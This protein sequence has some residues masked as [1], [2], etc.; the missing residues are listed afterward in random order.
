MFPGAPDSQGPPR[1]GVCGGLIYATDCGQ[2]KI[3][4]DSEN[5]R[6]PEFHLF[7]SYYILR[8]PHQV[9]LVSVMDERHSA[10]TDCR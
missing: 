4:T 10:I 6:G 5:D 7:A 1:Y 8:I 3:P 9:L 2:N